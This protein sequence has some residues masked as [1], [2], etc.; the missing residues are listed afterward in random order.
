M[1]NLIIILI[2]LVFF[3]SCVGHE[4][5]L[6]GLSNNF[7][8]IVN[9][10]EAFTFSLIA[11][12]YTTEETYNLTFS[13]QNPIELTTVLIVTD[14]AGSANDTSYFDILNS[15]DSLLNRFIL[16]SNINV[17]PPSDS[18]KINAIPQKIFLKT[19]DFSGF[20]QLVL[21]IGD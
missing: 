1:K 5:P 10:S 21:A 9:T 17:A 19:N 14:F 16:S 15:K 18:L 20:V 4:E 8:V 2:S 3:V 13:N 11:E 12:N 7:P 6:D